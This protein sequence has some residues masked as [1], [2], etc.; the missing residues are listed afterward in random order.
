MPTAMSLDDCKGIAPG[1]Q[2]VSP[3]RVNEWSQKGAPPKAPG[4]LLQLRPV[5]HRSIRDA[6]RTATTRDIA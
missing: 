3:S 2:R 6:I 4:Q 5:V 1:L